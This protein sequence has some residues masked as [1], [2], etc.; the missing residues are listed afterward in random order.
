[1]TDSTVRL[2]DGRVLEIE[3]DMIDVTSGLPQP[4]EGW[5]YT[6]HVGHPHRW[7]NGYP[8]LVL[9][10]DETYWCTDCGDEHT[11]DHWE[12]PLCGEEIKPGTRG[13]DLFRRYIPG[14]TSY[15]LDGEPITREQAMALAQQVIEEGR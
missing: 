5:T 8:T 7:D 3:V 15:S 1:M 6:D 2:P 10:I 9:V 11:D 12:C 14:L 13:P 4:D